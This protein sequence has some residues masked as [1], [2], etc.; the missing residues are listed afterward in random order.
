MWVTTRAASTFIVY[1]QFVVSKEF[2]R[3]CP[4]AKD[5]PVEWE[6]VALKVID[7]AR[8]KSNA[9][10]HAI[11]EELDSSNTSIGMKQFEHSIYNV[12]MCIGP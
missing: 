11:L 1:F 8:L 3:W 7:Y 2:H 4:G 6:I 5:F 10:V 9:P 12:C